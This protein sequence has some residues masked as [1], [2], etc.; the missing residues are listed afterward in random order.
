MSSATIQQVSVDRGPWFQTASGRVFYPHAPALAEIF[1]ED[2]ARSLSMQCRFN[3]HCEAFYS[4]AEHSRWVSLRVA[5]VEELDILAKA[6][7]DVGKQA[8]QDLVHTG[9]FGLMHD[10]AEA[11]VGD[12]VS[13]VKHVPAMSPFRLVEDKIQRT[14]AERFDF[15]DYFCGSKLKAPSEAV[16]LA[17]RRLLLTEKRDLRK[18]GKH[19]SPAWEVGERTGLQP[20]DDLKLRGES[21]SEA[22]ELFLARFQE[23]WRR[24]TGVAWDDDEIS[25]PEGAGVLP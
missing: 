24:K 11:Y 6:T 8:Y 7:S 20:Y 19:D 16:K 10:A 15:W 1:L 13:P 17:D 2:I 12:M 3:G 23:L 5:P 22:E 21:P 4:V 14:I 9:L 25:P 18:P